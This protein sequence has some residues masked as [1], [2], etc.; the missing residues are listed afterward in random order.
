MLRLP[1]P[2]PTPCPAHPRQL[3]S[4]LWPGYFFYYAANELTWGSMYI[5]DG[6]RN[7]DLIFML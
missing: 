7:N 5:G 4:L 2:F 1:C 3:R 6:L